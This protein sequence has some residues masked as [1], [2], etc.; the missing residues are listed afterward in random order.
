MQNPGC[1]VH[2][3]LLP[4]RVTLREANLPSGVLVGFEN[5][6]MPRAGLK[7][8]VRDSGLAAW[9][10]LCGLLEGREQAFFAGPSASAPQPSFAR[11]LRVALVKQTTYS[12]LYSDPSAQTPRELLESSWHR[13]GPIGLFTL[14]NARFFIVH[15]ESDPEC[16]VAE[17]KLKFGV[18]DPVRA[19]DD[20]QRR[21][22]QEQ[23][24]VLAAEVNWSD[25]DVV[26]A[27][28]NAVPARV[29]RQHPGVLWATLLEHHRMEQFPHYLRRPPDGYDAFLNLRFGPNPQSIRRRTHVIDWPYNF[30]VP[31]G[32]AALY[33]AVS[34]E[35]LSMLEDH[36]APGV[37]AA[38]TALDCRWTGGEV[39]VQSL[40]Q[41]VQALV[42]A[43][44]FCAARPLRPLGGL[45]L[46]DAVA[47]GC[48][49]VADRSRI[50]N[51]FLVT[52]ETNVQ[53]DVQAAKLAERL[54]KDEVFYHQ[55]RLEQNR[56]LAWF[57]CERPLR[58]IAALVR[59]IPRLLTARGHLLNA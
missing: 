29:T 46:I 43:K 8:W 41:F 13:T 36:Q 51:P 12:D 15:P 21:S 45:A 2:G 25:F 27:I 50:W 35:N 9:S 54:M 5:T 30:N 28:E 6:V 33:P 39:T 16:R 44:V 7:G 37:K 57:C 19:R 1:F 14:F 38:F 22:V 56:R 17:E 49:V 23:V 40:R 55:V 53:S 20:A 4:L 31:D 11:S 3:L 47:A 24:A 59:E 48:V 52:P 58:Q 32:I 34:R 42:R 10:G 18:A 26:I